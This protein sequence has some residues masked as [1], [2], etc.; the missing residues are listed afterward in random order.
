[1]SDDTMTREI[2]ALTARFSE[3]QETLGLKNGPFAARYKKFVGSEKQWAMLC[4]GKWHGYL[5]P[6]KALR[7]LQDFAK[8]LDAS[9]A[10]IEEEFLATMPFVA[11]M[12]ARFEL[13]LS[14][15][16]DRRGLICLAPEGVGKSWW[17]SAKVKEDPAH[18]SYWRIPSTCREKPLHL[19]NALAEKLS[20][21]VVKNPAEQHRIIC[22]AL[23]QRPNHVLIID[24]AHNGG[25][26]LMKL[27]KDFTDETQWRFVYQAF[28]TEFDRVAGQSLGAI[29]EARQFLRRCIRPHFNSYRGGIGPADVVAFMVG[30]KFEKCPALTLFANE[31]APTL[32]VNHNLSG[33]ADALAD[34]RDEAEESEV[35][36][37]LAMVKASIESICNTSIRPLAETEGGK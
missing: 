11:Q 7:R 15:E 33:L 4:D 16:K 8:F 14:S 24:E 37:T 9:E 34:A 19:L 28:P 18:R 3:L 27:L 20:V 26:A 30:N 6:E 2:T 36:L 22:A 23:R 32:A 31:V 17:A 13:L 12:D 21:D 29:A 1:M 5:K 25:L 35:R 10:F